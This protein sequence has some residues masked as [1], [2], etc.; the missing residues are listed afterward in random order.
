VHAFSI[1]SGIAREA[2]SSP[3]AV[4]SYALAGLVG[5]ERVYT[6]AHWTSDVVASEMLATSVSL[7]TDRWLHARSR[8]RCE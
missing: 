6:S 5:L 3:L 1:A 7:A 2:G 4:P 8:T